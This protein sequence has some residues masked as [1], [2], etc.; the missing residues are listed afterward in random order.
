MADNRR[1]RGG[2]AAE[3]ERADRQARL[4]YIASGAVL[5]IAA[6][7][8]FVGLFVTRYQPPRAQV[9]TVDGQ[10]YQARDVV[11]HDA[12][13][14]FFEGGAA[15]LSDV[16]RDTVE[17]LIEEAALR[18]Q[19]GQLVAPVSEEDI[20]Q[21][22]YRE[23]D[24]VSPLLELSSA[25]DDATATPTGATATP[26]P[27]P[28][29]T[30]VVDPQEFA[31]AL[32]DFLRDV[33]L[34]RDVYEAIVEARLYRDRLQD[35]FEAEVGESGRQISLQRIRVSKQLAADTV[36]A[37][38]DGGADF[39][40]LA[41]EQSVAEGDGEGGD[42]GWTARELLAENVR[43]AMEG[44]GAG[45]H[46]E[47]ITAGVF[48]EVYRVAEVAEDREYEDVVAIQIARLRL[49]EWFETAIAAMEVVRDLSAGEESWINEHVLAAV[50]P[51]LG[52]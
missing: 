24:L 37:D 20:R 1:G 31:E 47:A 49:D 51:R 48:F 8:V 5:A 30:A 41:A 14:T 39:A 4:I 12:Y 45:E 46:S 27:P 3:R 42:L 38:L 16:A 52:G 6:I 40:A 10:S 28:P 33:D 43:V 22:L 36:I 35:H 9:L 2:R 19:A 23:L 11:D 21:A 29:P 50:S 17:R 26:T 44:L 32:T 25:V 15:S 7:A 34:D 13:R 18:S